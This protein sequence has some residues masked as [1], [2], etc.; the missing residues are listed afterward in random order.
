MAKMHWTEKL[1]APL[2]I[3]GVIITFFFMWKQIKEQN[4]KIHRIEKTA[5]R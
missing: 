5:K 1:A 4:A 3:L 2:V